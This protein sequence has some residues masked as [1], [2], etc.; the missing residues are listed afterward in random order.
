MLVVV[1]YYTG[2]PQLEDKVDRRV[3]DSDVCLYG[4][5]KFDLLYVHSR[6]VTEMGL[7]G[8]LFTLASGSVST[9]TVSLH[10]YKLLH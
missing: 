4:R 6:S 9:Q 7:L 10:Q 8:G 2:I 5:R 1:V 3:I